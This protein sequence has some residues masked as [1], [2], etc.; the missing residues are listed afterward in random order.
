[1]SV[2]TEA[3]EFPIRAALAW[4]GQAFDGKVG[5]VSAYKHSLA[6]SLF[7]CGVLQ[8]H[9]YMHFFPAKSRYLDKPV[10]W[11]NV[12]VSVKTSRWSPTIFRW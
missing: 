8:A 1:M 9:A 11:V 5:H 6:L 4:F 2:N 12:L 3:E 10:C 7:V